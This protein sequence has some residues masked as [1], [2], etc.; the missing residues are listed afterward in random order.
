M[1][2][3]TAIWT[4]RICFGRARL[5]GGPTPNRWSRR[6]SSYWSRREVFAEDDHIYLAPILLRRERHRPPLAAD[7]SKAPSSLPP[8]ADRAWAATFAD[9]GAATGYSPGREAEGSRAYG[10][11]ARKSAFSPA[12]RESAR[13]R[14]SGATRYLGCSA[15]SLTPWRRRP[16]ARPSAWPRR[17][18]GL[19]ARFT[20]FWSSSP[21]TM[22]SP[23]MSIDL[24]AAV[25]HRGRGLDAGYL[26]GLPSSQGATAGDASVAGRRCRSVAFGWT[27]QRLC[28]YHC[29][30]DCAHRAVD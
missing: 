27:W 3:G 17:P 20:G 10:V 15:G 22:T 23:T 21:A 6:W 5:S 4:R 9:S 19:L 26:A 28:R 29:Q 12:D 13:R 25:C 11:Q 1:L 7:A 16:A 18:A 2:M 8:V 24:A 30:R 14:L